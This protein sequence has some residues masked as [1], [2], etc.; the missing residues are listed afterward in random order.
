MPLANGDAANGTAHLLT[1]TG[2][3]EDYTTALDLL[4]T[5]YKEKDGISV[6]TLIDSARNGGLTYND[7]L[8][9][10]GFIGT[11]LLRLSYST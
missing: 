7:F 9:L 1:A 8:V 4:K 11:Q 5:Q 6:H 2:Q 3:A 10:P